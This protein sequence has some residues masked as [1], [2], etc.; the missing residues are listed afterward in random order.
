MALAGEKQGGL[1]TAR[2]IVIHRHVL[3]ALAALSVA[4]CGG[5]SGSN[6]GSVPVSDIPGDQANARVAITNTDML[7]DARIF[8]PNTA[9][10]IAS[11]T[12]ANPAVQGIVS[13]RVSALS[14]VLFAELVPPIVE[15]ELVQA[16]SIS[17]DDNDRAVV[18]Y[19]MAGPQTLGAVD[20]LT[21]L[22]RTLPRLSSSITFND[23]DVNAV[24]TDGSSAYAAVGSSDA[25][26]A[27]PAVLERISLSR[28]KFILND[29]DRIALSSFAGTSTMRTD[30]E[31]YVTS[32]NG[33]SLFAFSVSD[34][35]LLG[36]FPL[37]DARWVAWDEDGGRVAVVQGTPGRLSVFEQ[38]E[39]PSG[40]MNL[41]NTFTFPGADVPE[42]KSTVEIAGGKAF[43]AAGP[44]GVQIVCLDDG[45]VVG[46]IPTPDAAALGLDPQDVV[47]NAVSVDDDLLFISNGGAGVYVAQAEE[48]FDETACNA[49]QQIT[50][51]GRLQFADVDSVNHVEYENNRL[52]VAAGRG[53]VKFVRISIN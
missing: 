44:A 34:L 25:A 32:G 15:G 9:V 50:V 28:S 37:S 2:S 23:S 39:F 36:E 49:Q 26:F 17:I 4:A 47:T 38:G 1:A 53:G 7:L 3:S 48:D 42:S 43:I 8:E 24:T 52:L 35:T 29:I 13:A 22:S 19:N 46:A 10:P 27:A 30:S 51:L 12:S 14:L 33:G 11:D 5:G 20:Y 40:S 45:Q 18:S 6:G 31:I 21:R 16:T 41:L